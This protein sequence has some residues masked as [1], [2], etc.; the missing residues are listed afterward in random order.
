[1]KLFFLYFFIGFPS[2]FFAAHLD[3]NVKNWGAKGDGK[4][5]DYP[6]L[7]KIADAA[8]KAGSATVYFPSGDYYIAPYHT[9]NRT[10]RDIEFKNI[11]GL[12]IWGDNAKISVNGNFTRRKDYSYG[13]YNYSYTTAVIPIFLRNCTNVELSGIE[14]DGNVD[15]MKR[16]QDIAESG[17][18][19]LYILDSRNIKLTDLKIH[20]AHSDGLFV[21]GTVT[22][23]VTAF[24]VVSYRNARQGMSILQLYNGIFDN[25]SFSENGKTD[26][27]YGGHAPRAG[28]DIEPESSV[29]AVKNIVFNNCTFKDNAGSQFV[30]SHPNTTQDVFLNKCSFYSGKADFSYAVIVNA[31]NVVFDNCIFDLKG[32]NIYPTWQQ[33]GST[34]IFK[35]SHIKSDENAITAVS[36]ELTNSVIFENNVIEYT[37]EKPLSSYFPYI[38]MDNLVFVN[39][40]I[41]IPKKFT[42]KGTPV[43][44]IQKA[45]K[46]K[47]NKFYDGIKV[48]N[49]WVSYD[50]GN[51]M[52]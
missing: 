11:D 27:D 6:I 36:G 31:K 15:K 8:S 41:I 32:G 30:V 3:I 52:D 22:E 19:L 49:P 46:I 45:K 25:C 23:N 13:Q 51:K 48:Y 39:N 7:L 44:L 9:K 5:D 33:Q 18:H 28:V 37:G 50:G 14:L 16:E 21:E 12:K 43:S 34:S 4:T 42:R 40:R 10:I 1:M 38:Q 17:G 35:N 29:T 47:G 24:N 2:F 20:H 26:G